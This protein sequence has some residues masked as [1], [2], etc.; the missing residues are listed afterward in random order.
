MVSG[1]TAA[2][3]A[4]P[5]SAAAPG[6]P[7]K[8]YATTASARK[9][10][11]VQGRQYVVWAKGVRQLDVANEWFH[12]EGYEPAR[13][14]D[15]AATNSP[16]VFQKALEELNQKLKNLLRT[17]G[18][19]GTKLSKAMDR[20]SSQKQKDKLQQKVRHMLFLPAKLRL[21]GCR[22][23]NDV[24]HRQFQNVLLKKSEFRYRQDVYEKVLRKLN[25]YQSV[26]EEVLASKDSQ[27]RAP[28]LRQLITV[29]GART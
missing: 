27:F 23:T 26:I 18:G 24:L 7:K 21:L 2:C 17:T 13:P 14:R 25:T 4:A 6:Q 29:T 3:A 1:G 8:V 12:K 19:G 20:M 9:V 11:S 15:F 22:A 10:E 5:K 28:S 16:E